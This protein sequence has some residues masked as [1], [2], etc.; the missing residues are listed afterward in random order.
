M[1]TYKT[2]PLNIVRGQGCYVWDSE[3]HK[4]LD[5]ISG[6]AVCNLGHCHP[7]ITAAIQEQAKVLIHCSNLVN[8]PYQEELASKLVAL[9]GM[10]KV[11]FGNSGA[12][13]NEAAIKLA[14]LYGHRK[15]IATP[16]I[17]AMHGSF[18]GRTLATLSATG[19][20]KIQAGFAPL[21]EGFIHVPYNDVAALRQQL[22][23]HSDVVAILAEPIQG[24]GGMNVPS[25]NYLATLRELCDEFDC[26]FILDEIQSGMGRTSNWFGHEYAHIKPDIMT[27]AKALANG[28]PIG[29]CIAGPKAQDLF[30]PGNHGSTF[31]GNPMATRVA[32]EVIK[33]IEQENI[34]ANVNTQG[35]RL[36]AQLREQL[37]GLPQV[38]DIRGQGLWIGIELDRP[39][40]QLL[41]MAAAQGFILNVVQDKTIRLAPPLI[42]NNGEIDRIVEMVCGLVKTL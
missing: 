32:L 38:R 14:R 4:Y 16:K 6:V 34:L 21:V 33:V 23:Q 11:F 30:Q 7:A 39:C 28:I 41:P 37:A 42:I 22:E 15:G 19:N 20:P 26:L 1:N 36:V 12:E 8:H 24:E 40:T 35:T 9:S 13:A 29:A 18:H 25:P 2:L 10:S 3:G 27:L 17:I 5:T 31:G